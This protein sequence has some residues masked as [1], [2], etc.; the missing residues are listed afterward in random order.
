MT[1]FSYFNFLT[2]A[3][4]HACLHIHT[5]EQ[6]KNIIKKYKRKNKNQNR[7]ILSQCIPQHFLLFMSMILGYEYWFNQ[8]AV[9]VT[10]YWSYFPSFMTTALGLS[11]YK[12]CD[13]KL[14]SPATYTAHRLQ[15]KVQ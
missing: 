3:H 14:I 7:Q 1:F 15:N 2:H 11:G 9:P 13:N 10:I 12:L 8:S 5:L 4:N 6:N